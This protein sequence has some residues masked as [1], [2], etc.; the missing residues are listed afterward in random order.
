MKLLIIFLFLYK[1]VSLP[2]QGNEHL[3]GD[4]VISHQVKFEIT[5]RRTDLE[6]N[7]FIDTEVGTLTLGL[8]GITVPKTV[9]N[10]V[11]LANSTY[12]YGYKDTPFHRIIKDFMVQGGD[13][14]SGPP[15][16]YGD[17]F[18]DENFILKHDKRGRLSMANAGPNT[19]GGQFFITTKEDCGWLNGHHVVFGQLIDGFDTLQYLDNVQTGQHDK[20]VNDYIISK[21]EVITIYDS[22]TMVHEKENVPVETIIEPPGQNYSYLFI[23]IL[24]VAVGL[25]VR[26]H[27]FKRQYITDIKDSNYF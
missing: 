6:V 7:D 17:K 26:K 13:I 8:F 16:I 9:R 18:K 10:F 23:F 14:K 5:E 3:T 25:F 21:V 2:I 24:L 19:N 12:G 22:D 11:A 15:S 1:I 27:Y 4:P 20:P